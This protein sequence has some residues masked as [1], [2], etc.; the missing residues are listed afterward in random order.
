MGKRYLR[1]IPSPFQ[2]LTASADITPIDLPVNPLSALLLSFDITRT[3]PNALD[4]YSVLDALLDQVTSVRVL[5]K[6]EQIIAGSLRDL[7]M[8]NWWAFGAPPGVARG[9]QTSGLRDTITI[10]ILFGR[11]M[12]DPVSCFPAT[13]RGNLVLQMTSG[14]LQTGMT[15]VRWQA[16]TVELIEANP[17]EYCK[18]VTQSRTSVAGQFDAP[19][20]IGNELLGILLFDTGLRDNTTRNRSWG[21][22][23]LL[24]DNVEQNV[25]VAE[26]DTLATLLGAKWNAYPMWPGHVHQFDGA[27][28]G[29]DQ[30][31]E[32]SQDGAVGAKGYAFID[33]DPLQDLM[34]AFETQGAADVKIRAV[35]DEASAVRYL[36]IE[37]VKVS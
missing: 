11:R 21:Q 10:P 4:I 19:L 24:K 35:G 5:H 7:M 20:P 36:P 14:A 33:F 31:D 9:A 16:D 26:V 8:L 15:A 25:A 28:A 2:T 3:N 37:R 17:T 13:T 22:L 34:Y 12:F 29:L 32:A 30:S 23:R 1:T 18:Y 6:G 27:A